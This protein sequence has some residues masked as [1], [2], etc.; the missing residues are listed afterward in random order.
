MKKLL[1]MSLVF[2]CI[3]L[4]IGQIPSQ[5]IMA[6][7]EFKKGIRHDPTG[8]VLNSWNDESID[9]NGCPS[10]WNGIMCDGV[11]VAAVVLDDLGLSAEVDLDVLSNLTKLVKLSL[12]NNSISGK[13]PENLGKFKSLQYLDISDNMFTSSLPSGIGQ[14]VNLKNL[15]L[16]GNNFSGSIPESIVGLASVRFVDMSRNSLSGTL[17]SSLTRL[18]S[19]VYLNLSQNGFAKSIPKG[20]ELLSHLEVLD[21]SGNMLDGDLDAEFLLL[22][23]ASIVD[24][25]SNSLV[26]SAKEQEKFRFNISPSIKAL[27]LSHNQL[28]GLLVSN[29]EA[30]LENLRVLDLSYNQ[31][32][33]D[34]PGFNFFYDLQVLKLGNNKFFGFIPNNLLNGDSLVLTELDLSGN[35]LT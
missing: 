13:L 17:P 20:F 4:S 16:A 15:S 25:S 22:T 11:D 35:N 14:L 7:V 30:P 1:E 12:S 32:S 8:Y 2:L 33:G 29:G 3:G 5:D 19:L 31:F 10:S 23:T 27:N 26:I 28:T 24:F 6:L 9:F 18:E 34:L 21:L